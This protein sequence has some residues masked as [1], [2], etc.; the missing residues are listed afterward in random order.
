MNRI[1][2]VNLK[3]QPAKCH[4]RQTV[5]FLGHVLTP[6]GLLPN[7]KWVRA[8]QNFPTPCN[9][10]E[11]HL[12]LGLALYYHHFV[13]KFAEIASPLHRLTGKDV[14]WEWSKDCQTA[15]SELMR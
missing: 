14:K 15:F 6:Q 2:E 8:V 10:T 5:E 12:F 11:L 3:L 4:F 7:P 13:A 1:R 9:I